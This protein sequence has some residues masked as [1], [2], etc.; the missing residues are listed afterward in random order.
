VSGIWRKI[1]LD[2]GAAESASGNENTS[3]TH[4]NGGKIP[5]GSYFFLKRENLEG[6][7]SGSNATIRK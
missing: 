6:Y 7:S 4:Q 5:A 1:N 3:S 2:K